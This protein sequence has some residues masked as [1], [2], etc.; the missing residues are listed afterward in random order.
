MFNSGQHNEWSLQDVF[1]ALVDSEP[2]EFNELRFVGRMIVSYFEQS[3]QE[4]K[5]GAIKNGLRFFPLFLHHERVP[6]YTIEI[7][8]KDAERLLSKAREIQRQHVSEEPA[9][10]CLMDGSENEPGHSDRIGFENMH[11]NPHS[12]PSRFYQSLERALITR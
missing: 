8:V 7:L 12:V 3:M 2:T 11:T 4:I 9:V 6:P 1:T 5:I 10:S